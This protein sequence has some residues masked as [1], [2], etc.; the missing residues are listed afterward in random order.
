MLENI[1]FGKFIPLDSFLHKMDPRFKLVLLIAIIVFVFIT[2]NYFS[3]ALILAFSVFLMLASKIKLKMFLSN[4][5]PILPIIIITAILSAI[6]VKTGDVLVSF[7]KI[8]IYSDAIERIVFM[9]IRISLLIIISSLLSYT[10]SPTSLT[11]ALESLFSPLKY[12]GLKNAVHTMAMTMTI[13]LRFIPTLI[14]ETGKIMNAQKARGADFESGGI[15]KKVKA[16]LPVLVP[17]LISSVRRAEELAN[18]MECRCYSGADGRTR[19]KKLSFG[20]RDVIA[21]AICV[22]VFAGVIVLNILL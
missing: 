10:T 15:L 1:S 4:V 12:I 2:S 14:E 6:Y 11:S 19:Y 7:W 13:A 5:K 8:T 17:L 16:L 21:T 18:A 20:K 3:L 22:F 9:I